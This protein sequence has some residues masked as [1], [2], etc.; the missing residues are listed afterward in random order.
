MKTYRFIAWSLVL[1]FPGLLIAQDIRGG[2]SLVPSVFVLPTQEPVLPFAG[3]R[4]T[5]FISGSVGDNV[6]YKISAETYLNAAGL[7]ESTSWT[8]SFDNRLLSVNLWGNSRVGGNLEVKEAW[9]E[10]S[11]GD[12]DLRLGKQIVAWGLADG[13]NPT[14][15]INARYQ[16]TRYATTL[17]EQKISSWMLAATYYLPGN[18]GTLQGLLLP[19]SIPNK[20]PSLAMTVQAGPTTIV[21]KEDEYPAITVDNIEGG[22]RSL[23][24]LGNLSFSASYFSYLDRYPDFTVKVVGGPVTIITYTPVHNRI[25]QLGL[26]TAYTVAGVDIR[27]E[28]ALSLTKDVEG[29]NPAEKNP[30]LQG[31]LQASRSFINGTTTLSLAWAPRYIL[32]YKAPVDYISPNDQQ[33]ASMIR[34]YDG[35][36][37]QWEHGLSLRIAGKYLNETVQPEFLFL[38]ETSARDWLG[39]ASVNY[40]ISDGLSL[41]VG[42]VQYGSFLSAGDPDRELGTFSKSSTIDKDYYYIE[43]KLSF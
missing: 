15:T 13:N 18:L 38:A 34:K 20:L 7:G 25:H 42:T 6:S 4:G 33:A 43:I 16:G 22:L 17:D 35:Q 31:V 40:Q 36:A 2:G 41:K 8:S 24:Y 11:F 10:G 1:L 39:T 9:I 23:W 21:I 30:Y 14:D 32:N 27:S 26:D 37:Y 29:T 28:W 3:L 12:L 5:A 19:V